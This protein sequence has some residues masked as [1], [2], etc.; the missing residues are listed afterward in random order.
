VRTEYAL[1]TRSWLSVTQLAIENCTLSAANE[2]GRD[3]TEP[4]DIHEFLG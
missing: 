2:R 1:L 4:R 3:A